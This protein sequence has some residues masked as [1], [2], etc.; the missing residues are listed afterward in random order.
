MMEQTKRARILVIDD[1]ANFLKMMGLLMQRA[2]YD[3]HAAT[4]GV[5][6]LALASSVRPDLVVLDMTM[7]FMQGPEVCRRLREEPATSQVPILIMSSLDRVDDKL[8]GFEAG[9]DDYVTKP[10]NP[11]ELLARINALLVRSQYLRPQ[12]A[13]TIA[14]V[15]AKG[16][17]GVS[18]VALN[19]AFALNELEYNVTLAELHAG[20]GA[21]RYHLK[22]ASAPDYGGLLEKAPA[23]LTRPRVER[24]VVRHNSGVRLLLAPVATAPHPLTAEHCEAL[25][26][27]LEERS[28][29]LILDLPPTLDA[30]VQRTLQLS[31]S[32]LLITEPDVLAARCTRRTLEEFDG[33]N[34]NAA[35]GVV[36]VH[37]IPSGIVLTRIELENEIGLAQHG[38]PESKRSN[39]G[40]HGEQALPQTRVIAVIPP[41]P[42]GFQEAV[43]GGLPI[44]RM[45]PAARSA[46]ALSELALDIVRLSSPQAVR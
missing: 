3:F 13:R 1:D 10:I 28:D 4:N 26:S 40:L 23:A 11:K 32:V 27:V 29:Y 2:S 19:L 45:E 22:L 34:L 39:G 42:E 17:V 18:S 37:R 21:L 35:I 20:T 43:R 25:I 41:A 6:G 14:V 31:D 7:P 24:Y 36:V 38:R 33:W 30:A 12:M 5:E 16:G 8:K 15:G 44:V 46:Q 9:A